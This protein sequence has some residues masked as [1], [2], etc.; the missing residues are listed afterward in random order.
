MRILY[1]V[2]RLDFSLVNGGIDN[3]EKNFDTYCGNRMVEFAQKYEEYYYKG[4]ADDIKKEQ[5]ATERINIITSA[6]KKYGNSLYLIIDEY[7]NFTNTILSLHGKDVYRAITN[8]EGFYRELFKKF[9]VGFERIFLT[10]V[11]PIRI[12][13]LPL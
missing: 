9:K 7:D 3:V 13:V 6:A 4:F 11:S 2:M 1:Q 10:G 5:I 8:G 12:A